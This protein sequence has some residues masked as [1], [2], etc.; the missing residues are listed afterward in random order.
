M[1]WNVAGEDGGAQQ[2]QLTE[3]G[4]VVIILLGQA[5]LG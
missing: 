4:A 2:L 1:Q 3:Q 5:H